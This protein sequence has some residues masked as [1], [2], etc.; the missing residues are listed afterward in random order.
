[1]LYAKFYDNVTN[2]FVPSWYEGFDGANHYWFVRLGTAITANTIYPLQ[3]FIYQTS[4]IDGNV[5]GVNAFYA[6]AV[7]GQAYGWNDNGSN[8]FYLY[9]NFQGTSLPP[10]VASYVGSGSSLSVN[11]GLYLSAYDSWVFIYSSNIVAS[12]YYSQAVS[13]GFA[14]RI[15]FIDQA[16]S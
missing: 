13:A 1:M 3:L 11:N 14:T 10:G 8:V 4:Q 16:D 7:L 15:L 6:T 12:P 9:W 5:V 2:T